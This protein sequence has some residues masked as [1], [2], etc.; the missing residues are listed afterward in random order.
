M[1]KGK[2]LKVK[3]KCGNEQIIFGSASSAVSCLVCKEALAQP[4]GARAKVV[5]GARVLEVLS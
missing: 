4:T 3:C 2:F 1:T 5:E